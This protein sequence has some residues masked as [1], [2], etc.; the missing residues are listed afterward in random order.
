MKMNIQ[1]LKELRDTVNS[2]LSANVE[3]SISEICKID[4]YDKC[5]KCN[6]HGKTTSCPSLRPETDERVEDF[7]QIQVGVKLRTIKALV[8]DDF[9]PK[10]AVVTYKPKKTVVWDQKTRRHV[11]KKN[12]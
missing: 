11:F 5:R 1:E 6:K 7:P 9:V 2:K 4:D 12:K 8:C 10:C 3:L